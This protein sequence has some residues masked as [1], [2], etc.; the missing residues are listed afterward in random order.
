[1]GNFTII[2]DSP[3]Y[4]SQLK[5]YYITNKK[6]YLTYS[7]STCSIL[8]KI[9]FL[10]LMMIIRFLSLILLLI[11]KEQKILQIKLFVLNVIFFLIKIKIRPTDSR[12]NTRKL[13]RKLT[14]QFFHLF[15]F[16]S[17]SSLY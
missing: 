2:F 16:L 17:C 11:V 5:I 14:I 7:L 4:H 13:L 15:K 9:I 12:L 10:I 8:F 6:L 3:S 1:M